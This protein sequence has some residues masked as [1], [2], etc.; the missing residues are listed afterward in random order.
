MV[1]C[2]VVAYLVGF[3]FHN[4]ENAMHTQYKAYIES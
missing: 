1:A 4:N 2:L 3:K